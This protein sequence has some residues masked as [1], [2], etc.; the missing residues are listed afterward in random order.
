MDPQ[1]HPVEGHQ[2]AKSTCE[3]DRFQQRCAARRLARLNRRFAGWHVSP[4][5]LRA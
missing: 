3:C 1:V 2:P 4:T 5:G